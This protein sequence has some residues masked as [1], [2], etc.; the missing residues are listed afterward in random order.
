MRDILIKCNVGETDRKMRL[1]FGVVFVIAAL[2]PE[3][4]VNNE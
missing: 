2:D 4:F 3:W 1:L